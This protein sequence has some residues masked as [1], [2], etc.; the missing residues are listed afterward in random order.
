MNSII[1]I[2]IEVG[3]EDYSILGV[4]DESHLDKAISL[5]E[6]DQRLVPFT[7]N[8]KLNKSVSEMP[9]EVYYDEGKCGVQ[10]TST[11]YV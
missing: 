5:L 4:F 8:E 7:I 11:Q 10:Q 9:G 2:M 1:W 3:S 6:Q